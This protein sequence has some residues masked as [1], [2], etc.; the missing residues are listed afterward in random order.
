MLL[1]PGLIDTHVHV[2]DGIAP[3][4]LDADEHCLS[5]GSTTVLDAGDAG[6]NSLEGL[7]I[8]VARRTKTRV[9]AVCH[10]S[11]GGLI[12]PDA[13]GHD[14]NMG[15]MQN[16]EHLNV[17]KTVAAINDDLASSDPFCVGVKVR[18]SK[19]VSNNGA[20]EAEGF[21]RALQAAEE[22]STA[23]MVHHGGSS[24]DVTEVLGAMR[25]GDMYTHCFHPSSGPGTAVRAAQ[26][27][28][29]T[30]SVFL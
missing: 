21:R 28:L 16:I 24:I 13:Y 26:G 8:H 1:T 14:P 12:L 30:L 19:A 20:N 5:R 9:L 2:F 4:G 7:K 11:T 3:Y 23:L 25:S 29:S 6:C 17:V 22:T 27:W 18:L 10:I 15:E